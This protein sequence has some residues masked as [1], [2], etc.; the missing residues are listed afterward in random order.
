[1]VI[2][3]LGNARLRNLGVLCLML[4]LAALTGCSSEPKATVETD[5]I[6]AE[7]KNKLLAEKT[8]WLERGDY[9]MWAPTVLFIGFIDNFDAC[10]TVQQVFTREGGK[11]RCT[12]ADQAIPL[13]EQL[14]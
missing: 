12:R 10:V 9:G 1:L 7:V 5:E 6:L 3:K 8:Y 11:Y 4:L 13:S 2:R 14:P